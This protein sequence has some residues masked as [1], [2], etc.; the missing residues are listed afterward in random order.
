MMKGN[1]MLVTSQ[2][3]LHSVV[4]H[5]C[6]TGTF[7]PFCSQDP[8]TFPYSDSHISTVIHSHSCDLSSHVSTLDSYEKLR[9]IDFAGLYADVLPLEPAAF[10]ETVHDQIKASRDVL[11]NQ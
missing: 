7:G 2:I 4:S 6:A 9:F 1:T 11:M 10:L 8:V 5:F 3:R